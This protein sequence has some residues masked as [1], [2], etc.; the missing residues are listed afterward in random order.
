MAKKYTVFGTGLFQLVFVF[1]MIGVSV[2][3]AL[4]I[5]L[6]QAS[7]ALLNPYIYYM[8]LGLPELLLI[9]PLI[10]YMAVTKTSAVALMGNR[11]SLGQNLLALLVGILLAPAL[12]GLGEL[13]AWLFSLLGANATGMGVRVPATVGTLLLSILVIGALAGVVEEP[14]FRGVVLRGFG[15]ALGKRPAV[16]LTALAFGLVHMDAVGLPT[17]VLVGLV[18]GFM[19]WRSGAVLPGIFLHAGYNSTLVVAVFAL[20]DW[21][22]FTVLPGAPESANYMLTWVLLSIPFIVAA[23]FAYRLFAR[24]T[25]PSSAWSDR[26]YDA[27][28][29]ARRFIPWIVV[30]VLLLAIIAFTVFVM[31]RPMDFSQYSQYFQ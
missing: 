10:V 19:A 4:L 29:Q 17:R 11:T 5:A 20:K 2:L 30:G 28:I 16:F 15:S 13:V 7:R 12:Q 8:I 26:P 22:G 6:L 9:A 21:G 25:P 31:F 18:L 23:I 3:S 24:A 27:G 14:I 1:W